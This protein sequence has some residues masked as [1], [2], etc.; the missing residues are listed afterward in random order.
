MITVGT[1]QPT[2][3]IAASLII[4]CWNNDDEEPTVHHLTTTQH[5]NQL[6]VLNSLGNPLWKWTGLAVVANGSTTTII[7]ITITIT[8]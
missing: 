5:N 3:L 2:S 8:N 6:A 1:Q 4:V 7:K